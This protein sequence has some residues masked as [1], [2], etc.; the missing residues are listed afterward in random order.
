MP[1]V[2]LIFLMLVAVALPTAWWLGRSTAPA[3]ILAAAQPRALAER[4]AFIEQ[5]RELAWQHRDVSP[6]LSTIII[7][8]ITAHHRRRTSGPDA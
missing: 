2:T 1:L 8:E 5:L 3:P 7:D 6:E 4:E